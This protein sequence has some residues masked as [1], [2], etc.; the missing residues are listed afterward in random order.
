MERGLA[1]K[2]VKVGKGESCSEGGFEGV[3]TPVPWKILINNHHYNSISMQ[4][5]ANWTINDA[6]GAGNKA[7]QTDLTKTN[8]HMLDA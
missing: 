8:T 2:D 4:L 6:W 5:H 7:V 1:V 3:S